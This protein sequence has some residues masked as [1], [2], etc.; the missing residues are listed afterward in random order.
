MLIYL[1]AHPDQR[2]TIAEIADRYGISKNHLTKVAHNLGLGGYVR[3]ARGR[4]GGLALARPAAEIGIGDVVRA[5][6]PDMAL[7]P[8]FPGGDS[9]LCSISSACR[10]KSAL[11][12][13]Q[14]AFM[15]VLD[16]YSLADL[17]ANGE[18]LR[19]LFGGAALRA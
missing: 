13:A 1:A 10:L 4:G 14:T 18:P 3:T 8:C 11:Y 7:V 17:T 5:T 12:Q 2:P 6:E 16:S 19:L 9:P 15:D